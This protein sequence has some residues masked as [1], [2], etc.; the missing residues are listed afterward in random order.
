MVGGVLPSSIDPELATM[1]RVAWPT[2]TDPLP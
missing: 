2:V 1:I